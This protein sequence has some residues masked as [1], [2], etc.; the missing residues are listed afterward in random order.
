WEPTKDE[1]FVYHWVKL[2]GKSQDWV[3]SALG[4]SQAT[5]SRIIQRYER[6]Q[7]HAED[8]AR[9]RL[10]PVERQRSQWQLTFERNERILATSLRLASDV[11]GF[12]DVSQSVI[13]RPLSE[14][15]A[16]N[17]IRTTHAVLDRTGMAARFL[18]LAFRINMEQYALTK[19][20]PPARPEPLS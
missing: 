8:R 20:E 14:P 15:R 11:E 5:V 6:W 9:G 12:R 4:I 1:D 19:E 13:T 18:R 2:E 7:A 10:D 3:A 16:E 17:E